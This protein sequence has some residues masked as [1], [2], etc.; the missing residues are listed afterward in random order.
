MSSIYILLVQSHKIRLLPLPCCQITGCDIPDHIAILVLLKHHLLLKI[1]HW[2]YHDISLLANGLPT[3]L[4]PWIYNLCIRLLLLLHIN[5]VYIITLQI[6]W[7]IFVFICL[8]VWTGLWKQIFLDDLKI[9]GRY[10]LRLLPKIFKTFE[11]RL[12][13]DQ[14]ALLVWLFVCYWGFRV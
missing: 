2:P 1:S 10:L 8:L 3:C 11:N 13:K 5:S 12:V 9:Q 4:I 6:F 7:P 14:L